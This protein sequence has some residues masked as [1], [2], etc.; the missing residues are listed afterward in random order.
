MAVHTSSC[1]IVMLLDVASGVPQSS[2][3]W[4][5]FCLIAILTTWVKIF[6]IL[7]DLKLNWRCAFQG[8]EV[9]VPSLALLQG[10]VL[11]ACLLALAAHYVPHH[12]EGDHRLLSSHSPLHPICQG[13]MRVQWTSYWLYAD[14][15]SLGISLWLYL[16]QNLQSLFALNC[17]PMFYPT[18]AWNHLQTGFW[19]I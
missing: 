4:V 6:Q 17:H 11:H 19:T 5:H 18:T 8:E 7:F 16:T 9:Y 15:P 14:S 12:F 1:L 13:C 3:F 2:L 10:S